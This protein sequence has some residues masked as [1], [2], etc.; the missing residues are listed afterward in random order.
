MSDLS[1]LDRRAVRIAPGTPRA[2]SALIVAAV[3]IASSVALAAPGSA[4]SA[5]DANV[6][7]A[8]VTDAE[9]SD[10][11]WTLPSDGTSSRMAPEPGIAPTG[12]DSAAA[13][14]IVGSLRFQNSLTDP[15]EVVTSG[16]VE[17][18]DA[19]TPYRLVASQ[20]VNLSGDFAFSGVPAG[21]YR[22]AFTAYP[23]SGFLFVRE[24]AGEQRFYFTASPIEFTE[25]DPY[26]FGD[27]LIQGR[28][29]TTDR[30]AGSD[31]FETAAA[32]S[33]WRPTFGSPSTVYVVNGLN[34]PDALSA[35][36]AAREGTLLMVR[37][38]SVPVAT[39][40]EL[41]R[42]SPDR[43]V[44]V[45]G[46]GVVS[47]GVLT[48][49][50]TFVDSAS[51][52]VRIAGSD[53]YATSRAVITS[54]AGF[55][56]NVDALFIAT[57]SNFPDALAAVPAA[58]VKNAA[59]LLVDG[60]APRLDSATRSLVQSLDVPVFVVG[61][62]GAVSNGIV[63]QL[64]DLVPTLRIAGSDRFDTSVEVSLEFFERV[65]WAFIAN[66]FGFADALAAG[67][68]AGSLASPV[69]LVRREC[70]PNEVY[71]DILD[72]VANE[73]VAIGGSSVVSNNALLGRPCDS[74]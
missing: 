13:G 69:Y 24:W 57:G 42:L 68:A 5:S 58:I 70:V 64:G 3:F 53:R 46:T 9:D 17:L 33:Q 59:V 47:N 1:A 65:D 20:T 73:V 51:D 48:T 12:L 6:F 71:L 18:Y 30:V 23:S 16:V 29:I 4:A 52:V 49:L 45:G 63:N 43:I 41:A 56:R 55:D 28:N 8:D 14:L 31:R 61:G 35:G 54:S 21:T 40:A 62:S 2:R 72:V 10:A 34:F 25:G 44:V 32:V 22:A 11:Q 7:T 15:V 27:V 36:A 74:T 37:Q 39:R 26:N 67:P 66:G 38:N 19:A 60:S 50:R